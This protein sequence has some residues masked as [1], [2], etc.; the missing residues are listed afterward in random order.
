MQWAGQNYQN[1]RLAVL[2]GDITGV[3]A[4]RPH[5]PFTC[6]MRE[7]DGYVIRLKLSE[8]LEFSL[9]GDAAASA[10]DTPCK[11]GAKKKQ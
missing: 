4:S 3:H 8:V 9:E 11:V 1:P 2:I 10:T 5:E 6:A 7:D